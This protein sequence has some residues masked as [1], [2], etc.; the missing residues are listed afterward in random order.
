[1]TKQEVGPSGESLELIK[2][3]LVPVSEYH[4]LL[5][6][7]ANGGKGENLRLTRIN[8]KVDRKAAVQQK[9]INAPDL[10]SIHAPVFCLRYQVPDFAK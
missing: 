7:A 8:L 1:M 2:G 4:F 9:I 5:T 6:L 10:G 3:G